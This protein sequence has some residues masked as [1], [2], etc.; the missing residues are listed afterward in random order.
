[1]KSNENSKRRNFLKTG[2]QAGILGS[3]FT[4]SPLKLFSSNRSTK[5]NN[6]IKIS[7]HPNAVKRNKKG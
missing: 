5:Q 2:A 7:I 1:M 4:F 6:G 3:I